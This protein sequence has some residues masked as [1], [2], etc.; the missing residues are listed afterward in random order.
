MPVQSPLHGLPNR[1][2]FTFSLA[3]TASIVNGDEGKWFV[4]DIRE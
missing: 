1:L 3:K 4:D 2:P